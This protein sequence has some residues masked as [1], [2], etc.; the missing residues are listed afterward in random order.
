MKEYKNKIFTT[1]SD[2]SLY[3][4]L[5]NLLNQIKLVQGATALNSTLRR[6]KDISIYLISK[7]IDKIKFI[8]DKYFNPDG[9]LKNDDNFNI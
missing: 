4:S 1:P 8:E 3:L 7:Q 5:I 6:H 9:S 2:D